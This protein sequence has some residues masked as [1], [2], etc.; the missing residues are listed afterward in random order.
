VASFGQHEGRKS[1]RRIEAM[2]FAC[3]SI[4]RRMKICRSNQTSREGVTMAKSTSIVQPMRKPRHTT[5]L[6]ALRLAALGIDL[7]GALGPHDIQKAPSLAV[8][9]DALDSVFDELFGAPPQGGSRGVARRK[10]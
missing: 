8:A 5:E 9:L 2:G 1:G 10:K 3:T 4:S 6:A 7:R